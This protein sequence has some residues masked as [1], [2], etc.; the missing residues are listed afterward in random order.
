[1]NTVKES[2]AKFMTLFRYILPELQVSCSSHV[3]HSG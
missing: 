3:T 1:M 2:V